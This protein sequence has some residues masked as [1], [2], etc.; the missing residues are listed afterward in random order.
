MLKGK[1][2]RAQA[3]RTSLATLYFRDTPF[4][5]FVEK[6]P[7]ANPMIP[8]AYIRH[9]QFKEYMIRYLGDDNFLID[10][11]GK[12][13]VVMT[14]GIQKFLKTKLRDL[15]ETKHDE[16]RIHRQITRF[17][18]NSAAKSVQAKLEVLIENQRFNENGLVIDSKSL[19]GNIASYP[20]RHPISGSESWKVSLSYDFLRGWLRLDLNRKGLRPI[21]LDISSASWYDEEG[22]ANIVN[23][24]ADSEAILVAMTLKEPLVFVNID[25]SRVF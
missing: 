12:H 25:D 18:K 3:R 16:D 1:E 14:M 8:G 22:I 10:F 17:R 4:N 21:S 20:W 11:Y 23:L 6:T 24:F 2:I 19:Y 7:L 9:T 15:D 5:P 13:D